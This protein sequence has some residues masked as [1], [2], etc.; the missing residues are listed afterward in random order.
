KPLTLKDIANA[1]GMHESTISRATNGKYV[2]TP[3]GLYELKLFF[4]SG[5]EGHDGGISSVSIKKILKEIIEGEDPKKPYSDNKLSE[6]IGQ[7][8]IK[9]SRRT[10]AKY[11]DELNIPPSNIRKRY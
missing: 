2:Q 3:R 1:I 4:S 10:V 6:I 5:V 11:R 9:I 8:G 7:R